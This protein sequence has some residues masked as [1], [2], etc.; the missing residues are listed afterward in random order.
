MARLKD[1]LVQVRAKNRPTKVLTVDA[2]VAKLIRRVAMSDFLDRCLRAYLEKFH[3][4]WPTVDE[5]EQKLEP[6]R[7]PRVE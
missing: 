5:P 4:T 2:Q 1:V 6:D 3:P 7:P